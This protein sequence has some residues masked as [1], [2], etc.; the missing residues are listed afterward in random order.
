[1]YDSQR[2]ESLQVSFKSNFTNDD[3]DDEET[4]SAPKSFAM[5]VEESKKRKAQ[6]ISGESDYINCDFLL[7]SAAI[8]ESLWSEADGLLANKKKRGMAPITVEMILYLKKN[9]DLW[10]IIDVNNA[11][12]MRKTANRPQRML[13]FWRRRLPLR[14]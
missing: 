14:T 11:N 4:G 3:E 6:E 13:V 9:K 10:N 7:S 12:E 1:M 8:V 5:R 2:E